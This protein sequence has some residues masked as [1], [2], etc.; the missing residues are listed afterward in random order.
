MG[1][2]AEIQKELRALFGVWI[3]DKE[4]TKKRIV[5]FVD[6]VDRCSEEHIIRVI[7]ALKV[8]M[9]DPFISQRAIVIA[10][11]DE[12]V[13]KR[14]I[15]LKYHKMVTRDLSISEKQK[16]DS[17]EELCR[18][19]MDKLF[20]NE[21]KL[22]VLSENDK[23]EIV[24]SI[25]EERTFFRNDDLKEEKMDKGKIEKDNG[26]ERAMGK[27]NAP[28]Q[29]S[30]RKMPIGAEPTPPSNKT[31][32]IMDIG[33][34]ITLMPKEEFEIMDYE[35]EY[36]KN[37]VKKLSNATP[38]SIRIFYYR[39]LLAKHFKEIIIQKDS[40]LYNQW[41]MFEQKEILCCMIVEYSSEKKQQ[42]LLAE[43]K[44]AA[45][46]SSSEISKI[47][48]GKSF[49]LSANLYRALLKVVEIVVPY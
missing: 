18:E 17:L 13:L 26:L 7:D 48:L 8:M 10:A 1:I 44:S 23:V 40:A 46:Y 19:Y 38:R 20:L 22:G 41:L 31:Q 2:Q 21:F 9:D 30:E 49:T 34:Y 32:T 33:K 37:A 16:T 3:R 27:V 11:I 35:L 43:L 36:I 12:T 25:A 47:L 45:S 4:I 5:L 15:K 42:D 24:N 29:S 14:A 6:D 39:Y 28:V